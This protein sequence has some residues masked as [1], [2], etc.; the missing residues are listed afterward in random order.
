MKNILRRE[1]EFKP[2]LI[3]VIM[4]LSLAYL[5][6]PQTLYMGRIMK[7]QIAIPLTILIVL[8][9]FLAWREIPLAK[10]SL[11]IPIY[12][13][14]ITELVMTTIFVFSGMGGLMGAQ[15]GDYARSNAILSDLVNHS[16][17]VTYHENHNFSVL[18]YY[19]AYFVPGAA[20]GKVFGHNFHIAEIGVLLWTIAG[21]TL[22]FFL[23]FAVTKVCK[24]RTVWIFFCWAGLDW[25]GYSI[26]NGSL[27]W[28]TQHLEH[29]A[30]I[31][32]DYGNG[33]I[34]NYMSIA[35]GI[36]WKVQS[37]VGVLIACFFILMMI[38]MG[39]YKLSVLLLGALLF[40][41]PLVAIGV[42]PFALVIFVYEKGNIKKFLSPSDLLSLV[43]VA[44]PAIL[45]FLSMNLK[46]AGGR[47]NVFRGLD[48]LLQN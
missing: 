16:W 20:V 44:L 40:W 27:F 29:W 21:F 3:K 18:N 36:N 41:S 24:L 30:S 17:P 42:L 37:Y 1:I 28:G 15:A 47:E 38:H 8:T 48:W 11:F 14:I 23:I 46:S 13:V 25:I 35:S 33:H 34:A 45:Y 31:A 6:F 4:M 43:C 10:E 19:V 32:K 7:P 9:L 26:V 2:I 22:G 12:V 39:S 5:I